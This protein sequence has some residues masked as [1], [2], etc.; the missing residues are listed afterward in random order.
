MDISTPYSPFALGVGDFNGDGKLDLAVGGQ[1][2]DNPFEVEILLGNGDGT[3]QEGADY[4][5]PFSIC[6][7][8]LGGGL[9]R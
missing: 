9:P 6:R 2:L 8:D 7:V 3:F 4:A 5:L 1:G